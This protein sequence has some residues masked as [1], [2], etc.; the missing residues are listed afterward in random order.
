MTAK[1]GV[2][3]TFEGIEGAGKSTLLSLAADRLR[4]RGI[5]PL[6]TREPGGTAAG[7]GIRRVLLDPASRG[8]SPLC[9]LM[10]LCADRA[11]HVAE[12]LVPALTEG[13]LVLC[14]RFS[15]STYAYQGYGRGVPL[16]LVRE[17]DI[18][19]RGGISPELTVLVDLAAETGLAR[20][21]GRNRAS[22]AT[23]GTAPGETRF[24]DEEL[25]F[26]LRVREGYL[27]LA[28]EEKKR[29]LVLDGEL[30]AGELC[31]LFLEGLER[32]VSRAF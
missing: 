9:E 31:R 13:R 11:Q 7:A 6:V 15:D 12:V 1:R 16:E 17:I 14:D 24:D 18:A 26:H 5:D 19:A 23:A 28:A 27:A 30:P 2:L 21:R 10:L 20:A 29:F 22:G 32:K 8:M 4:A 3:V 25:S